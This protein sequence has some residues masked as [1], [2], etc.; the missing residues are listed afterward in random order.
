[1][2]FKNLKIGDAFN[3]KYNRYIKTQTLYSPATWSRELL[4]VNAI[5]LY[6]NAGEPRHFTDNE[7]V[8][9][10]TIGIA[11]DLLERNF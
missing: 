1:M 10:I 3:T 9:P 11:G 4:K 8:I 5:S 2:K 7:D 6:H